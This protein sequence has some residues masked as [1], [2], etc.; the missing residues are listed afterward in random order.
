M[1][2]LSLPD[3][4]SY[5]ITAFLPT[6][7][8]KDRAKSY[9]I[10]SS[11]CQG[12][13]SS[14]SANKEAKLNPATESLRRAFTPL[15]VSRLAEAEE[16]DNLASISFLVALFQI[17]RESASAIFVQ[18]GLIDYVMDSLDIFSSSSQL[19][20]EVAHLL[21]QASGLKL[22][23]AIISAHSLQWLES[24]SR[25]STD[26]ALRVA[27]AIALVKLLKGVA[28]DASDDST[29]EDSSALGR[30]EELSKLMKGIVISGKEDRSSLT[31]AIEGLAYLSADPSV[32][33]ALSGD[34][35]F[36]SRLFSLVPRRKD[37]LSRD[38][39]EINSTLLYGIVV[40]ISNICAYRPHLTEEEVQ[41][42]KL[43]RIAKA[44]KGATTAVE[45][46]EFPVLENEEY[47][48]ERGR[49]LV[50]AGAVD[51]LAAVVPTTDSPRIR[52][53][54]G[55]ALLSI[56]EDKENR[57][58]VLQS[59]GA[60]VLMLIFRQSMSQPG[61]AASLESADLPAVQALAKLAI[62]SSPVQVF[63]PDEGAVYDAIRPFSYMLL[64]PS[65]TLLQRFEVLMALTNLS[66]Q[67]PESASRIA[68]ADGLLDR[69]ELLLLEDHPLIRRA[70]AELVCNLISGSDEVFERYGGAENPSGSQ[71]KLQVLLALSDVD[72]MPTRLAASGAL[73]I[74]TAAPSA[75][76]A[77]FALHLERHRVLPILT[78]L[79]DPS[80]TPIDDN[81]TEDE[82]G[83]IEGHPGLVHRGVICAQNFFL[84]IQ[85]PGARQE[86]S[87]E[88]EKV[89]LVR[90]LVKIV[91][92]Q[93]G[94]VDRLVLQ[95]AVKV[96]KLLLESIEK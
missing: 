4:I 83:L 30:E 74:L 54:V 62:T 70:A 61:K 44:G 59:G 64:H 89:G 76:H 94:S 6:Q 67:S 60:K 68:K 37:A 27:A 56:V 9:L 1:S 84:S 15:V 14:T 34:L 79:I 73:A 5:L 49:R 69:V 46:F 23:R 16:S 36:L 87:T 91:Q 75:C 78:Q 72:D 48:K 77:L 31:D 38:P 51:V 32:K 93:A 8:T 47:C 3:E 90:A 53:T 26:T 20:L 25:Q 86:I 11:F 96:L 65:S 81:D 39:S 58:K 71:S 24:K 63:G 82:R 57:G 85:A 50:A 55:K 17:D 29:S 2:S 52:A 13:R 35:V 80:I 95:P 22:C 88:A 12:V 40:I 43:R 92:G 45:N 41:I 66:S 33:E 7:P 18:D 10:L 21:G 19:S 28:I 42:Q